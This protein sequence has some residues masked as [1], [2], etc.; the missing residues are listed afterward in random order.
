MRSFKPRLSDVAYR[1]MLHDA[2]AVGQAREGNVTTSRLPTGSKSR[3][4][5]VARVSR[6]ETQIPAI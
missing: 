3:T 1:N 2:L 5:L 4:F 6:F